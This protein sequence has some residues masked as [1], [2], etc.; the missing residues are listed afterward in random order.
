MMMK[1]AMESLTDSPAGRLP[2]SAAAGA[3]PGAACPPCSL[4]PTAPL[5]AATGLRSAANASAANA[6]AAAKGGDGQAELV[7]A[8]AGFEEFLAAQLSSP[9]AEVDRLTASAAALQG[10]RLRPQLVYLGA[11][12]CGGATP[13]TRSVAA[14]VEMVHGATLVH[15]DILD[16]A[17][18]RRHAPAAH[19][20][21][22]TPASV[23]LGDWL[24]SKAYILAADQ[25]DPYPAQRVGRAGLALC[26][27]ELRQ[28]G[29]VGR[30]DLTMEAYLDIL[31]L[32]TGELCAASA[33]LGA[34]SA[35]AG[36]AELAAL[37][38]YGRQLGVA[39]Q[40]FDDWL[41]VWGSAATGKPL[42][43]DLANRRPTLPYLTLMAHTPDQQRAQVT[44]MLDEGILSD[45]LLLLLHDCHASQRTLDV[46]RQFAQQATD[47]LH[48]LPESPARELLVQ[49]AQRSI[50]RD[51]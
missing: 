43:N 23:L 38:S 36:A 11:M 20:Q 4:P 26:E 3:Y 42:G 46:A 34:W 48:G 39:F 29:T 16:G 19:I 44:Q 21:W 28:Q 1:Q 18:M 31:R 17:T 10:K 2:K 15:D 30:W 33:A 50:R 14:V 41:D 37:E 35:G 32:K 6:S 5:E 25:A 24:F 8:M 27:G 9:V 47:A 7:Q 13:A 49:V 22:G 51:R 12:A 45:E 40:L